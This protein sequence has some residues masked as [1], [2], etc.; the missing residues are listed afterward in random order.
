[1]D[2]NRDEKVL[3]DILRRGDALKR[4]G[5]YVSARSDSATQS[6]HTNPY[7]SIPKPH[8]SSYSSETLCSIEVLKGLEHTGT[9]NVF[10]RLGKVVGEPAEA[11]LP[12]LG[13][14]EG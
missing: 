11:Q 8:L 3:S 1:L 10:Y 13:K 12:T 6:D 14:S 5:A 9:N 7:Q 2:E 4:A